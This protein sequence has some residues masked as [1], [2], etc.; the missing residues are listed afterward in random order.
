[1]RVDVLLLVFRCYDPIYTGDRCDT[2]Q[3][4]L[5]VGERAASVSQV[6]ALQVY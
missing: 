1:M 3:L 6:Y 4:E 5:I 2:H